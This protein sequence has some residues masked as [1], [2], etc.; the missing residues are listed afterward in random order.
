MVSAAYPPD[1]EERDALCYQGASDG[2]LGAS[3]KAKLI[4]RRHRKAAHFDTERGGKLGR[5]GRDPM[6]AILHIDR[7]GKLEER[8]DMVRVTPLELIGYL[9]GKV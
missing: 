2:R 4:T 6:P 7:I 5:A 1:R 9:S 3:D 8:S